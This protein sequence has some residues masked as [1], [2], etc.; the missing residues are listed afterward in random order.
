MY[1]ALPFAILY[2]GHIFLANTWR[3]IWFLHFAIFPSL[4]HGS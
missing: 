2:L 3:R 1:L 4:L